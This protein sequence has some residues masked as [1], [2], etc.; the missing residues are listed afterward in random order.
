MEGQE[1][2][3]AT[4]HAGHWRLFEE[5][6]WSRCKMQYSSTKMTFVALYDPR[7]VEVPRGF[8]GVREELD[9]TQERLRQGGEGRE[10][11]AVL[12]PDVR[13]TA[14]CLSSW[15][16]A[17]GKVPVAAVNLSRCRMT[18][19]GTVRAVTE[20]VTVIACKYTAIRGQA[21]RAHR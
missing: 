11:A 10:M 4:I 20:R 14:F 17:C 5:R 2:G 18:R 6:A 7:V 3:F 13:H 9:A 21:K 19:L 16:S 8:P 12:V 1:E 15:T